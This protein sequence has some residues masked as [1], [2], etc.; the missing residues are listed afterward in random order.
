MWSRGCTWS[1]AYWS[2]GVSDAHEYGDNQ[3][4]NRAAVSLLQKRVARIYSRRADD[5]HKTS[6]RYDWPEEKYRSLVS[7]A[8]DER[9]ATI[10]AYLLER[11]ERTYR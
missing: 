3:R 6:S 5:V 4:M 2:S 7:Q 11:A 1:K 10:S 8:L 9:A